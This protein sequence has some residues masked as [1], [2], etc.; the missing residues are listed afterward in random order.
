MTELAELTPIIQSVDTYE[1]NRKLGIAFEAQV[2]KGKLFFL[3]LDVSKKMSERP[4]TKQ[5]LRSITEYLHSEDF[6]PATTIPMHKLDA[7]FMPDATKGKKAQSNAA[8]QQL[9]NQ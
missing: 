8:I 6:K 9:L 1:Y 5:L 4:A 7:L 3:N 2:G